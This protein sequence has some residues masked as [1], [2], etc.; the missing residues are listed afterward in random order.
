MSEMMPE[1]LSPH[2][3]STPTDPG[4]PSD[5]LDCI[6]EIKDE[7][8]KVIE[9]QEKIIQEI[10][11]A[12]CAGGHILLEGVP[13]VA[14]TLVVRCLA[15]ALNLSFS[16]IQFTPDLMPSDITGVNVYEPQSGKFYFKQG[17][18]FSDIVLADEV[19]R[20]PAKTQA[21]MLEAMQE[22]Q[23]T[24]D[25]VA[26][27]LSNHF[28][29]IA[30]QNPLEYEG[31]YPLPEAQLDRFI[32]KIIVDYP[33]KNSELAM[34]RKMNS[35]GPVAAQPFSV[36]RSVADEARIEEMRKT[37]HEVEAAGAVL[38]Y[39]VEITQKSRELMS[40]SVG[41]SPRASVLM[42]HAAKALAL[43]RGSCFVRPDEVRDVALPLLRHRV[44]LTP[45]SQIEGLT[46]DVCIQSL[47]K[48]VT[49]PR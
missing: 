20:A 7:L 45:E 34:L 44:T 3:G 19:N 11:T 14:K 21:A 37:V 10:L 46:P 26:H 5:F 43:L 33:E 6:Q 38:D 15:A 9:G 16:R 23:V 8:A 25:G 41:A 29:V 36:I 32:M 13:G 35:L 30:T 28:M 4:P 22:K 48:Q 31:T 42:L 27:P 40:L 39:I 1:S 24:I 47:I 2:M 12:F 17:P 18:I 49:V